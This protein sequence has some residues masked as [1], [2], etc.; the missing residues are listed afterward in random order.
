MTQSKI[1]KSD[2]PGVSKSQ[3]T[4]Q[5]IP[6]P[7]QTPQ[8]SQALQRTVSG[9]FCHGGRCE[10]PSHGQGRFGLSGADHRCRIMAMVLGILMSL[11]RFRSSCFSW[12]PKFFTFFACTLAVSHPASCFQPKPLRNRFPFQGYNCCWW[13]FITWLQDTMSRMKQLED[14]PQAGKCVGIDLH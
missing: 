3:T 1:G 13:H 11:A 4:W 9:T 5:P 14:T 6:T 10:G 12:G 7:L 2:R 8:G